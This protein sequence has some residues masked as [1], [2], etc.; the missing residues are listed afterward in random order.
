M[1]TTTHAILN[2]ALLGRKESPERNWPL[3]L[4]SIL[5]DLPMFIYGLLMIFTQG[6]W[7][8]ANRASLDE[9]HFRQL[10]VDWGHSIPLAL[11]GL[12]LCWLFK[13]SWGTFFFA[14]MF[15]HDLEDLPL[16]AEYAHRHFLPFSNWRFFSPISYS[17][18]HHYGAIVAPI[19]WALVL[20]CIGILW[21]RGLRPHIQLLLLFIGIFQGVWLIY[22]FIPFHWTFRFSV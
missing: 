15:L 18:P 8:A 12:L 3:V 14:A 7:D 21:K 5:P 20:F 17:D 2:T 22:E 11:A 1:I 9:F 10:W 6:R 13:K 19:E 16:H 4:G